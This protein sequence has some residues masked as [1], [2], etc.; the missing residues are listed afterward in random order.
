MKLVY[1]LTTADANAGT[2]RAIQA[3]IEN[4]GE[5]ANDVH[6]I[7]VY[8]KDGSAVSRFP[9]STKVTYLVDSDTG[10]AI[11]GS[12]SATRARE[13]SN[14]KS[15]LV[16]EQWDNQ[17]TL[18]TDK[19]LK[20]SLQ[21]LGDSIIMTTTPAL[22]YLASLFQSENSKLVVQE[23]RASSER[24]LGLTPLLL[25]KDSIDSVVSLNSENSMWIKNRLRTDRIIYRTIS[26][27]ISSGFYP[28][29]LL[30]SKVILAA[31]RL[32][33]AKQFDQLITAF[34]EVHSEFPDWK[35][36]IFGDGPDR[37]RLV[38]LVAKFNLTGCVQIFPPTDELNI[39]WAKASIHAMTSR[40]EGQSLV[41]MEA[42]AAGVP[43]VAYDCPTGPRNL[44]T[45]GVDGRLVELNSIQGL[46]AALRELAGNV[47]HRVELGRNAYLKTEDF[48]PSVVG[49]QWV[50]LLTTLTTSNNDKRLIQIDNLEGD[51]EE[52]GTDH[53]KF[54]IKSSNFVQKQFY[55]SQWISIS[56]SA[57]ANYQFIRK[58]FSD[59]GIPFKELKG[60]NYY[61]K[62]LAILPVDKPKLYELLVSSQDPNLAVRLE[63]GNAR[64][65][66]RDWYPASEP[67][68]L[69]WN[70]ASV[71]RIF[72][73]F[74]DVE[75]TKVVGALASIDVEIWPE[76]VEKP[77]IHTA[78][79]HNRMSDQLLS[80]DFSTNSLDSE[81]LL[82][83]EIDYPIDVVYTWVDDTDLNW[84]ARKASCSGEV[85]AFHPLS[86]S[87]VRFRNR[88]ELLYSIRSLRTYAPWVNRIYVVTDGQRPKWL[89]SLSD[90]TIIDHRD[91]FPDDSVLPTFNS[92]AIES[93]LHRIPG[94]SEHFLYLNDDV[95]FMRYQ[96]PNTY[97]ESN[98]NARL[99]L[100]PVKIS[101]LG[102]RTEPHMW[103]AINNRRLIRKR[104]GREI[105]QSMLHT[106]HP[107]RKSVLLE[108]ESMFSTEF[109]AV[110][111]N[112][113]RSVNDI[114]VLSSLA[115]Y[116]GYMT[117]RY[118]LGSIRYTYS[119]IGAP[120]SRQRFFELA[121]EE[122]FDVLALGESLDEAM[123]SAEADEILQEFF[124]QKFPSE[125]LDETKDPV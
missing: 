64:L 97:F 95:L 18:L 122:R 13:L 107:H 31:G 92:H 76:S 21:K 44:I 40:S 94:L 3:Q 47:R 8:R 86:V 100:S 77:G 16:D 109:E 98:G 11:D 45:D 59:N 74:S 71:V 27:S 124:D 117:G 22:S 114:S 118:S 115:Q 96:N 2:E 37:R 87:D 88:N 28:R 17:F 42:A 12:L 5:L 25:A 104:F 33:P 6:V 80:S 61:R 10:Q 34:R 72:H 1:L 75:G 70:E 66:N 112:R 36:R 99:F 50:E 103:A 54:E 7:S 105:T 19:L 81:N 58:L 30:D 113:F 38:N 60:Y 90:I 23:H 119:A 24:G 111:K 53:H 26:N 85:S 51:R 49:A 39:E 120:E 43:T 108:L 73:H 82:W 106:P 29:S 46:I 63:K 55:D 48:L 84:R 79:R 110:R 67:S 69:P 68:P 65:T 62:T 102:E 15:N 20:Q 121:H 35:L 93:C 56:N 41:I 89:S 116:F 83:N 101:D 78:P 57:G 123:P 32:A 125:I 52:L 91:I 9:A 14:Q 4:L